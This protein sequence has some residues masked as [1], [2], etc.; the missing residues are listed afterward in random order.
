MVSNL[1]PVWPDLQQHST[2]RDAT[3]ATESYVHMRV[4]NEAKDAW[5]ALLEDDEAWERRNQKRETT[6]QE[7]QMMEVCSQARREPH[8]YSTA[9]ASN[10]DRDRERQ[11]NKRQRQRSTPERLSDHS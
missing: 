1:L 5:K 8:P 4:S 2:N 6:R 3:A 7:A 9:V 10:S 11:S